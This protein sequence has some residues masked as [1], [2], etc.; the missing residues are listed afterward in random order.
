MQALIE[1]KEATKRFEHI[2]QT[3]TSV[4]CVSLSIKEGETVGI[5]GESGS[6]KSTVARILTH[7]IEADS[8]KIFYRGN[9]VTNIKGKERKE[10]YQ[11]V[12]MVFQNSQDSFHPRKRLKTSIG[13]GLKNQGVS[14]Q[15]IEERIKVLAKKTGLTMDLLERYPHEVSGGQCQRAAIARAIAIEPEFIVCDEATSSLDAT[16]QQQIIL[17]IKQLQKE[18]KSFLIISHDIALV[19]ELCERVFVMHQGKMIESGT[20]EEVILHPKMEYTKQL[21]ASA[22]YFIE[23]KDN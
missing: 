22:S 12:Q 6:G 2:E 10:F 4:N 19:Q 8:G 15:E 7:L 14:K 18:G 1:L 3:I 16:V 5:V 13:M 20:I 17:L 21:I 9:D 23:S 11:K